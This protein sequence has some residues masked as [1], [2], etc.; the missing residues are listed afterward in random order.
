MRSSLSCASILGVLLCLSSVAGSAQAWDAASQATSWAKQDRD[1]SFTFYDASTR[2]LHTWVRDGG[3]LGTLP[4][5]KL[6]GEP[7]RWVID[8]RQNAWVVHDTTLSHLDRSGRILSSERLPA[9]VSDVCW[10]AVGL[11]ISYRTAEPYVEKREYRDG[12]VLWSFGAKPPKKEGAGPQNQ[13]P[14]ALDDSGN[15]L[16]ADGNSL[17]LSILDANSGRK[18]GET[19]L[20]FHGAPA[21]TLEGDG[22]R[23]GPLAVWVGK[24]VIFA[25][26]KAAQVPAAQRGTLQGLV[27]ARLDLPRA[28]ADFL[29]T[30]LDETHMLVGVLDSDAVFVNPKGGLMLVAVK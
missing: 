26:L 8:P 4:L 20:K 21:P 7:V 29:P 6:E 13:R 28:T 15:I 23:R 2:A 12:N 30:G 1:D 25:A 14:L 11:I 9:E 22:A 19:A 24:G 10:D 5:A 16:M 18:I 27:L 3:L 17:N